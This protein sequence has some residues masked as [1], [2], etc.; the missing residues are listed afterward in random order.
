MSE[1]VIL[2]AATTALV[3]IDLQKGILAQPLEPRPSE[4]V[5]EGAETFALRCRAAGILVIWV[6]VG[7]GTD[8]VEAPPTN[9]DQP[10]PRPEG[11]L[12]S[13]YS[14]FAPGLQQPGDL[15]IFKRNWGAFYGTELDVVLRRRA[16]TT[17]MLAGVATPFGVESTARQAWERNYDVVTLEDLC[18][19]PNA[20]LH[21]NS[22]D[23]IFPRLSRVRQTGDVTFV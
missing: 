19:A 12:P 22:I 11:G 14:D 9:V 23:N 1:P 15:A 8:F 6:H 21:W 16:V 13:N 18:A 7:F 17:I 10:I 3:M 2:T 4:A 5:V 20:V